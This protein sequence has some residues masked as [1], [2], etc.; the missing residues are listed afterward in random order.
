MKMQESKIR[1]QRKARTDYRS[2]PHLDSDESWQR[3]LLDNNNDDFLSTCFALSYDSASLIY[4]E[5]YRTEQDHRAHAYKVCGCGAFFSKSEWREL[6]RVGMYENLEL[7]N[8]PC[9]ST[10]TV[11]TSA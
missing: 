7:R 4:S 9:G 11:E 3:L 2:H 6:H 5:A 8:C 1:L 10:L